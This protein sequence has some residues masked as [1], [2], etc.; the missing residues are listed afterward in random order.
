MAGATRPPL[1]KISNKKI[2]LRHVT[3]VALSCFFKAYPERFNDVMSFLGGDLARPK[4]VADLK[5]FLE[6]NREEIERSL[7]AIVPGE[8]HQELGLTDGRWISYICRQDP[9]GR[10]TQFFKA[11]IELASDWRRLL[12]LEETSI[13]KKDYRTAD[14]AK[15][16][17]QTIAREDVLS[18]LSRKAVI[19]KYGFPVDVVELDT[20]RT[21]HE[22][23]EIELERDLKIAIAEFAPTSQLIANKKLWTSG[24]LKRVVDREWEARYYRKCPVHGRFDVWNPGEEPPGTTCCSNMTARRQY[25]IPAFGFVTSRD[26]PEDPKGRPARMF[27]T[28][29]F[30]IGLFG[31]ERG[32]TSMPQQSPLLRVSKTCPGKMG[33]ICEGRRGSGFFVCPECGAGFRE[34][35]KKSHRAPTGQSCSGKPLIVSLGHEFITDVVKIEFLRPVPGSIEPTWFAYSLAYALAGGA[36]GVLE[37]PPEDLSTTVAYADTPY[38]PP[39][40]IYDNVPG[41]AGLVARLEEVEIMRACLEAAYGR[42]Q[43]GCGC[44][45]NDSCYGC[46]RNYTNQFAHQKLRRGPVKDF[47]DQLLAEWPR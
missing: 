27:S 39:I 43:G 32:F 38:V 31:S 20:Q 13:K 25:I 7:L 2:V 44:G 24:G 36:A 6:E 10:E 11:E 1:L 12:E 46:L 23:D 26:K 22:A 19:P 8:M 16:R 45:E 37:V 5:A 35:P 33:V 15:R 9:E 41:G 30:F 17:R 47:L 28:R 4:A 3:A 21:G 14:W 34:R 18:F 40:V 42:V 29:P